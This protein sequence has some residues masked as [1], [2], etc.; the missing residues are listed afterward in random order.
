M[1]GLKKKKAWLAYT[2][3]TK[4][5]FKKTCR[6]NKS[7]KDYSSPWPYRQEIKKQTQE[8]KERRFPGYFFTNKNELF[9]SHL[10]W[11]RLREETWFIFA[12]SYVIHGLQ[13]FQLQ[14]NFPAVTKS[15]NFSSNYKVMVKTIPKW[16][17]VLFSRNA[18]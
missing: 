2:A 12:N 13:C 3:D 16:V 9:L 15:Y 8:K 18:F 14:D 4:S 1:I 6:K 7:G 11:L 10:F 17:S 5:D